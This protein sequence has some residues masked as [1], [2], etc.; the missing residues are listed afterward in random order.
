MICYLISLAISLPK[1]RNMSPKI[2]S[3]PMICII[4]RNLSLGFLPVIISYNV[5]TIWPPSRAGIGSRF[6]TPSMIES[7]ARMLRKLYQSHAEGNICPIA[8]KLP[9]DL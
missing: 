1:A 5:N 2:R 8:M 3:M 6:I 9:T 4:Y 7:K